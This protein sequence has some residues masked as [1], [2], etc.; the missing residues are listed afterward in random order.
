[1][2]SL[3]KVEFARTAAAIFLALILAFISILLVSKEP[4]EAIRLFVIGPL[5]KQRYIGNVIEAMIPLIFSGV[6]VSVLFQAAQ[7]NMGA[8][9]IF[10]FC[11]LMAAIVGITA[12][13]PAG[14]HPAVC[15]LAGALAGGAIMTLVGWMKAKLGVS[16]LVSSLMFNSILYGIGLYILNYHF[17]EINTTVLKSLDFA[18]TANLSVIVPGTN[19]HS[20]LIIAL[21]IVVLAQFFI[22]R[23]K[24]GYSI[25]MVGI[26]PVFAEYSGIKVTK[27]ILIASAAAGIIAGMGGSV[28]VLGMYTS[29][30][31]TALPGLG[32]DGAVIAMLA[33]NKPRNVIAAAA[34]WAYIS[35]GAQLMARSTDI[36]AEMIGI[37][38]GFIILLISGRQFMQFYKKRV[39]MK[40]AGIR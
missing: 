27:T 37:M 16:E 18:E 20:G 33:K 23:T 11:G 9:G 15:I 17:R 5:T 31:W 1:M 12:V 40:E 30:K 13:L 6:A 39:L 10:Y 3:K 26:N 14:I 29:F 25:R 4:F 21:I 24:W 22:Y 35:V 32:F 28:E 34:F 8:E 2:N 36:P 38:Q 7:F 19:I